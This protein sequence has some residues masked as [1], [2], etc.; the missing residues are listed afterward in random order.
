MSHS[1][2]L[3]HTLLAARRAMPLLLGFV[4][5][6]GCA[7]HEAE[8]P[9]PQAVA[10]SADL[11]AGLGNGVNLQPSYYNGGNPNFG[12]SLM[13]WSRISGQ[14]KDVYFFCYGNQ[15]QRGVARQTA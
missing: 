2:I 10:A 13:R 14:K 7:K 12:W 8:A 1:R 6:N 5:L 3:S 9:T 4:L 11:T 15:D